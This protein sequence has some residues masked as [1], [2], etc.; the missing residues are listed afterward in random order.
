MDE[1]TTRKALSD[2]IIERLDEV[3]PMIAQLAMSENDKMGE[4]CS[5]EL[6]DVVD[7]VARF[8]IFAPRI[9]CLI[10]DKEEYDALCEKIRASLTERMESYIGKE[11][12]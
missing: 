3:M 11:A 1:A 2:S 6:E 12:V 4:K 7:K 10:I 8:T 9:L 5:K